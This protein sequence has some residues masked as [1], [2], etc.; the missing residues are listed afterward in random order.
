MYFNYGFKILSEN[1]VFKKSS[2][3][4]PKKLLIF[5]SR[6][7]NLKFLWFFFVGF[8]IHHNSFFPRSTSSTEIHTT[9][10]WKKQIQQAVDSKNNSLKKKKK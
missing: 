6:I 10:E 4:H 7:F 2:P 1:Y 5:L 9:R 8:K 3:I